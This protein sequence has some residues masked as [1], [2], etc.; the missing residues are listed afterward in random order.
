M[1]FC[2]W[3]FLSIVLILLGSGLTAGALLSYWKALIAGI[4][5]IALGIWLY[6]KK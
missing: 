6:L 4:V 3:R 2:R 1:Y 5:L